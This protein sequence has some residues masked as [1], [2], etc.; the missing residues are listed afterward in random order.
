ME[1]CFIDLLERSREI[2]IY[3]KETLD[4]DLKA[5]G[6]KEPTDLTDYDFKVFNSV[7]DAKNYLKKYKKAEQL[8]KSGKTKKVS[9]C[10]H[11][12]YKRLYLI[13]A[14]TGEKFETVRKYKRDWK[15]GQVFNLY[16]QTYYVTVKLKSLTKFKEEFYKY[17]FELYV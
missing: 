10:P 17:E 2:Y 16:D 9:N 15:P 6:K 14:L 13:Q 3:D 5:F 12:I 8:L 11:L 7:K 4:I 1:Y